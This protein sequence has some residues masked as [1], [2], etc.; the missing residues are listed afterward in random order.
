MRASAAA[1]LA[2]LSGVEAGT[3]PARAQEWTTGGYDAQRSSW[4][5]TDTKISPAGVGK[6]GF[7]FLWK[8]R[9]TDESTQAHAVTPPVL[10]DLVISYRGFRA[11]GV[12]GA[13]VDHVIALDT[14]LGR[15]EWERRFVGAAPAH[16]S[17]P[18]CAALMTPNLARPTNAAFPTF[19]AG[20]GGAPAGVPARGAVGEPGEGAVTLESA[21]PRHNDAGPAPPKPSAQRPSP[22]PFPVVYALSSDGLLHTLNVM[23]GA[24]AEPPMP[25]LPP[26]AAARGLIVVDDVA[27][28][29]TVR[30]CGEGPS[31]VWA[32]DLGSKRVATWR[33]RE[34]I[35]GSV[36]LAVGPD[37]TIYVAASD[38]QLLSLE[39]RTLIPKGA[40][41]SGG[42]AFTSSPVIFEHPGGLLI[43]ASSRDGRIRLL[44]THRSTFVQ[45]LVFSRDAAAAPGGLASWV[46]ADGTR[47]L[48]AATGGPVR[49]AGFAVRNGAVTHGAIVAWKVV[50]QAGVPTL[51]PGWVSRDI[52]APL[53]PAIV[54]GVVFAVSGGGRRPTNTRR[55]DAEH[56]EGSSTAI[57]YALNGA[58]GRELWSSEATMTAVVRGGLS[59]GGGQ[60]YVATASGTL[61]AFGFPM[62]H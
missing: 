13:G 46:D 32:L 50:D 59:A 26:Y 44:D 34:G 37:G 19:V 54:N 39:P 4:V 43:A 12:V 49:S 14:D 38:G 41:R 45:T 20:Y 47:W 21:V 35:V 8:L 7:Q 58:T 3:T 55:S 53:A 11:L 33:S 60:V 51:H 25:F 15:I 36:G 22:R 56:T 48:L 10:L 57:L 29:A 31:G 1:A 16:G 5:R 62:E 2:W 52:A 42:P 9:V 27:Y 61:Y 17:A 18:P 23:N 28:V 30:G 6:P 40:H 24:D